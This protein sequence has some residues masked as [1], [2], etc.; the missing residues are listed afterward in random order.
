[1]NFTKLE[2]ERALAAKTF[3]FPPILNTDGNK[4]K[5]TAA[6]ADAGTTIPLPKKR[7]RGSTSI[8]PASGSV[9]DAALSEVTGTIP[10]PVAP[11][12]SDPTLEAVIP[13]GIDEPAP[14]PTN[15]TTPLSPTRKSQKSKRADPGAD[16][17]TRA[18]VSSPK[19]LKKKKKKTKGNKTGETSIP[20]Q[21]LVGEDKPNSKGESGPSSLP[22]EILTCQD[23]PVGAASDIPQSVLSPDQQTE[24]NSPR[25]S[26]VHTVG[27]SDEDRAPVISP[28]PRPSSPTSGHP[29]AEGKESLSSNRP[30]SPIDFVLTDPFFGSLRGTENPDL[31]GAAAEAIS[32][33]LLAG[34]LFAK[35]SQDSASAAEVEELR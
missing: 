23:A 4:R 9:A 29:N 26:P 12:S 31:D 20:R 27:R 33:L 3:K 34:C 16:E 19:K 13:S 22:K 25:V 30:H 28:S 35:L 7:A 8:K 18:V 5:R 11:G 17:E 15:N 32:S 24:A 10:N 1:M 6:D 2:L 21:D 14:N